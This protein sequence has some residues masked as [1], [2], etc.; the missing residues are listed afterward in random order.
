MERFKIKVARESIK[1]SQDQLAKAVRVSKQTIH[2]IENGK[3]I[4]SAIVAIKIAKVLN[5]SVDEI[6]KLDE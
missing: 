2:Y 5:V 4:P 3:F 1:I 6:F